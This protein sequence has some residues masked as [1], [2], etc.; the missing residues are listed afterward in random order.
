MLNFEFCMKRLC[1]GSCIQKLHF[2]L[3]NSEF[4][5]HNFQPRRAELLPPTLL[6][7]GAS[8]GHRFPSQPG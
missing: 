3:H 8:F 6:S 5:I 7:G 1:P 2:V 4:I